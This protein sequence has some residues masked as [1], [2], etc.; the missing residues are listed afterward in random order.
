T[1]K[2]KAFDVQPLIRDGQQGRLTPPKDA[3]GLSV[4]LRGGGAVWQWK[5]KDASGWTTLSLG[6][7]DGP[8]R[9]NLRSGAAASRRGRETGPEGPPRGNQVSAYGKNV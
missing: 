1:M 5:T 3:R 7:A 9:I 6:S 8:N 4:M 2:T